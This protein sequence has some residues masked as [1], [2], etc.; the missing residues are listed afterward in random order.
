MNQEIK[1]D[2]LFQIIGEQLVSI[3][4]MNDQIK[5]LTEQLIEI[6]TENKDKKSGE[7]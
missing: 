3:R 6:Q 2:I 4:M 5:N 1:P 7:K